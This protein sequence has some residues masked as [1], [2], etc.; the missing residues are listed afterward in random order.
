MILTGMLV[1]A[2]SIGGL[3]TFARHSSPTAVHY[4][5]AGSVT[6]ALLFET[7]NKVASNFAF[8]KNVGAFDFYASFPLR[9]Q[10]LILSTMAAFMLLAIPGVLV[11]TVLGFAVLDIPLYISPLVIPCL[12]V[13][14][15]PT[16]GLGAWLGARSSSPEL[17]SSM[18]LS[19]TLLLLAA[20]PVAVPPEYL[21]AAVRWLGHVNPAAYASDAIRQTM[22][23]PVRP[24][25]AG[26]LAVMAVFAVLVWCLTTFRMPW[27]DC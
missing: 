6:M 9:R 16:A 23:G 18:S 15:L 3:G 25:L 4:V 7:Q 17:A 13:G 11:T 10:A 5:F 20:G 2:I 21:P 19:S 24:S 26:D 22:I 27:R 12:I 1:P 8:M 14:A